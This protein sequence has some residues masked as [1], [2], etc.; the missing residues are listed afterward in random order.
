MSQ[1][2]GTFCPRCGAMS[3]YFLEDPCSIDGW[4]VKTEYCL[5]CDYE[6]IQG[7]RRILNIPDE[8]GRL[9]IMFAKPFIVDA[10]GDFE[11]FGA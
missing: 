7:F 2:I 11:G 10:F 4:L 5:K 1:F 9:T 6:A 8:E 3:L